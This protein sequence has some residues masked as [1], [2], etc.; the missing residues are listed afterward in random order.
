M[1]GTCGLGQSE[2]RKALSTGGHP[3]EFKFTAQIIT[4]DGS[5]VTPGPCVEEIDSFFR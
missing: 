4:V 2:P 1:R 3:P 5:T